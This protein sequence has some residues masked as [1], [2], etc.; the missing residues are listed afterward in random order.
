MSNV[1][2]LTARKAARI[3]RIVDDIR[4][5]FEGLN[6]YL[7]RTAARVSEHVASDPQKVIELEAATGKV[8]AIRKGS[9]VLRDEVALA[10]HDREL[11]GDGF[12]PDAA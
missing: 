8:V 6:D 12:G 10:A 2:S 1:L 7:D 3:A 11:M 4:G 5:D 9:P